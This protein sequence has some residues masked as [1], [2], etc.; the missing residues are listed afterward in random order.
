MN[1]VSLLNG[2]L[3]NVRVAALNQ[4]PDGW[5][6]IRRLTYRDSQ[7]R[8]SYPPRNGEFEGPEG[9]VDILGPAPA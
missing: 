4:S 5:A 1:T 6:D 7:T 9:L 2:E 8:W 3:D